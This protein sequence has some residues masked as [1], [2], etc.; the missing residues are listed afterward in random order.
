[1]NQLGLR[2]NWL[3]L[4]TSGSLPIGL[5]EYT[6]YTLEIIKKTKR[7]QHIIGWSTEISTDYAHKSHWTLFSTLELEGPSEGP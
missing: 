5:E 4:K 3:K 2:N 1:M 6:E 7:C